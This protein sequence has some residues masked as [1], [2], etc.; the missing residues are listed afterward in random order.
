YSPRPLPHAARGSAFRRR[1]AMGSPAPARGRPTS[2]GRSPR[3]ETVT[4]SPYAF[5]Y[6]TLIPLSVITSSPLCLRRGDRGEV[7][8]HAFAH[9]AG[10]TIGRLPQLAGPLT[11]PPP[12]QP[13]LVSPFALYVT[14]HQ[15]LAVRPVAVTGVF[16][17]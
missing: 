9:E 4:I 3:G 6:F 15:P 7:L 8:F 16:S 5:R 2:A 14:C 12:S 13:C 17:G 10:L 1:P 11:T